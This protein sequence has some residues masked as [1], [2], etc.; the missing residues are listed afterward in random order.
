MLLPTCIEDMIK[1]YSGH[2]KLRHKPEYVF[3]P[4]DYRRGVMLMNY[5]ITIL[6][7][8]LDAFVSH[9]GKFFKV[10]KR[11]DTN[12]KKPQ[13]FL[14]VLRTVY[15]NRGGGF[16]L[17]AHFTRKTYDPELKEKPWWFPNQY[18]RSINSRPSPFL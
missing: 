17:F 5:D 10:Y 8:N 11:D 18:R 12:V 16:P 9:T 3:V 1:E 7:G 14:G 4:V 13:R 2:K 6:N 15:L